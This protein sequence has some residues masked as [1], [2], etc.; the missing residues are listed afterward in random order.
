MASDRREAIAGQGVAGRG[1]NRP[2]MTGAAKADSES[3]EWRINEPVS[4]CRSPTGASES[5]PL[6]PLDLLGD[7]LHRITAGPTLAYA[8]LI[9]VLILAPK[10]A[11]ALRLPAMVGLVLAGMALGPHGTRTLASDGLDRGA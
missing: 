1:V 3:L 6:H 7:I 9:L 8:I 10:I 5:A 4:N 11:E 2:A